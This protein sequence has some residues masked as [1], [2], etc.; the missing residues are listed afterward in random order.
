MNSYADYGEICM[1]PEEQRVA[2]DHIRHSLEGTKPRTL[3]VEDDDHD[4]Y[5]VERVLR[6]YGIDVHRVG[7]VREALEELKTGRYKVVFL[8]LKLRPNGHEDPVA[9]ITQAAPHCK[10]IVLTGA[11][12]QES[13]HC[14]RALQSGAL[15]IMLKPLTSDQVEL[16]Y[17]TP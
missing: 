13:D 12:T 11:Y 14:N 2:I 7:S 6:N 16:I 10:V 17:G 8:D 3:V 1:S 5:L 9:Q 4:A 15:A